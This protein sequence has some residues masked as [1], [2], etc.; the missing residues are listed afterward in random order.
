[1]DTFGGGGRDGARALGGRRR[2]ARGPEPER[3]REA[4]RHLR[5][6]LDRLLARYREGGYAALAPHSRRPH[7]CSH[8][9]PIE[10]EAA[11]VALRAELAEA[12]H[13]AGPST[14]AH[15]LGRRLEALPS[16][17]TVW[18]ILRRHGLI[19]PQPHKRPRVDDGAAAS[20]ATITTVP[21][22]RHIY[23]IVMENHE[24]GS[25]IGNKRSPYINRLIR[26]YGLATNDRAVGHPSEPT[27]PPS[28]EAGGGN[29]CSSW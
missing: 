5:S 22:F 24:Y 18:R 27:T 1:M 7:S 16:P 10:L 8:R 28:S 15:H 3:D 25:I 12:G 29:R 13:D 9:T 14:I 2:G 20:S 21:A 23:L 17:A 26:H 11:I 6:W 4:P 19:T